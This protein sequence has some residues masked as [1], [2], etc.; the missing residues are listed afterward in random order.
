LEG[1]ITSDSER[2][3]GI[4]LTGRAITEL[5]IVLISQ[6]S[7][8]IPKYNYLYRLKKHASPGVSGAL[9]IALMKLDFLVLFYQEKRT[10]SKKNHGCSFGIGNYHRRILN[11]D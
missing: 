4:A 6:G 8:N 2:R 1:F 9:A 11:F 5:K 3:A 7:S 10:K